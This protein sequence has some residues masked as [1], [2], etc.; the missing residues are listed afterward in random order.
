[1]KIYVTV[2]QRDEL[3]QF[4]DVNHDVDALYAAGP[5]KTFG[6]D[7]ATYVNIL[8][9]RS[10]AHLQRVVLAYQEKH[11]KQLSDH[12]KSYYFFTIYRF[13]I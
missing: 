13:I 2:G 3:G 4:N 6:T 1:M 5:G 7:E 11:G 10:M 9:Q 12:I 8:S